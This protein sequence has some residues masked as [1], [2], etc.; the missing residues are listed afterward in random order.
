MA[1][2]VATLFLSIAT[3]ALLLTDLSLASA[4]GIGHLEFNYSD[5]WKWGSISPQFALCSTGKHQ[6]PIN[7]IHS[8]VIVHKGLAPLSTYYHLDNA[9]LLNTGLSIEE[10][11]K[12]RSAFV[13]GGKTYKLMQ[14]HW[15]T[16]SEHL[17]NGV[18]YPAELHQVHQAEDGSRAVVGI[19]YKYGKPD[20]LVEK[21]QPHLKALAEE[22]CGDHAREEIFLR[23]FNNRAL[24]RKPRK[25]YRYVGSLTTPPCDENVIWT[26]MAKV[27]TMSKKQ[28]AAL[29]GTLCALNKRNSRPVQPLNGR[30]VHFYNGN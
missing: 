5:P 11:V 15:H 6:S 3:M 8:K 14:V 2:V 26:V 13:I 25:Y 22:D 12:G 4:E 21:I 23:R 18:Q 28:V 7:I 27:K 19:L 24:N 16:P 20:A 17:L 30:E 9:T 10:Q 29:S 1:G